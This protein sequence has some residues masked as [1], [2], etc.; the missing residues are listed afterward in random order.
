MEVVLDSDRLNRPPRCIPAGAETYSQ[1]GS[2]YSDTTPSQQSSTWDDIEHF[3][4]PGHLPRFH[5]RRKEPV[6][7]TL[8]A[9]AVAE[10]KEPTPT[11]QPN[12][13]AA[14]DS[15]EQLDPRDFKE[16]QLLPDYTRPR[17][18]IWQH[19]D[20]S[21]YWVES[22]QVVDSMTLMTTSTPQLF[23]DIQVIRLDRPRG[24]PRTRRILTSTCTKCRERSFGLHDLACPRESV[25]CDL[26]Y[27][28][29]CGF[30]CA[31]RGDY[32]RHDRCCWWSVEHTIARTAVD[33]RAAQ[34][35]R[36][37]FSYLLVCDTAGC[38]Y[39][40]FQ[41]EVLRIHR[42]LCR[43]QSLQHSNRELPFP[44]LPERG[45]M[46]ITAPYKW[47]MPMATERQHF[48]AVRWLQ[49]E[50]GERALIDHADQL[51][52][53]T[54]GSPRIDVDNIHPLQR[55]TSYV[56]PERLARSAP[57]KRVKSP[58]LNGED[59]RQDTG[60]HCTTSARPHTVQV[61][62]KAPTPARLVRRTS[63]NDI[64]ATCQNIDRLSM[65]YQPTNKA[66]MR[67]YWLGGKY[68]AAATS[69]TLFTGALFSNDSGRFVAKVEIE[70]GLVEFTSTAEIHEGCYQPPS[71]CAIYYTGP[72]GAPVFAVRGAHAEMVVHLHYADGSCAPAGT[73]FVTRVLRIPSTLTL[74][75]PNQSRTHMRITPQ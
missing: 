66:E 54:T 62:R 50:D 19:P 38:E 6:L 9:F 73:L 28:D 55:V 15:D 21:A 33:H 45:Q 10:R 17:G 61:S 58:S 4:V 52:P 63:K 3:G 14:H 2:A 69:R 13:E 12:A 65:A 49:S 11:P 32:I 46:T 71:H 74:E 43:L 27:C 68:A 64:I 44:R 60:R 26:Y 67:H 53:D 40:T 51:Q 56:R 7:P 5:A 1:D 57:R 47:L 36:D 41:P 59:K 29:Y 8:S 22:K 16:I 30:S 25:L 37:Q 70:G 24:N 72:A 39:R 34:V 31:T 20:A 18:T 75:G 23:C 48:R 42:P 35:T